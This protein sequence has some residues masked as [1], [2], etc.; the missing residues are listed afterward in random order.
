M[1]KF[2]IPEIK[3]KT[4][5]KSTLANYR[6]KLNVLANSGF[7]STTELMN[8]PE[9]VIDVINE[10]YESSNPEQDKKNKY[11]MYFAIFYVLA[12]TDY[13]KTPNPYY[14]ALQELK[15]DDNMTKAT[16]ETYTKV[17]QAVKKYH[18]DKPFFE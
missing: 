16:E 8:Q 17:R 5:A 12:D 3:S 14:W 4:I 15:S 2:D 11:M 6:S 1:P 18:E 9:E 7:S 10:F 13:I